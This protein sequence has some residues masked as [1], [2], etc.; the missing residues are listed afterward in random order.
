MTTALLVIDMQNFFREMCTPSI[1]NILK[2]IDHCHTKGVPVV[3]TQHGHSKDELTPP[4]YGG[5]QLVKKWGPEES[6]AKGSENWKFI[7]TFNF[8]RAVLPQHPG[9]SSCFPGG[10]LALFKPY[11]SACTSHVTLTISHR[12]NAPSPVLAHL[13]VTV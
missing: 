9:P 8:C 2:L 5:S 3:F 4:E 12:G 13:Q 6:I 11:Q 7:R 10:L 1:P